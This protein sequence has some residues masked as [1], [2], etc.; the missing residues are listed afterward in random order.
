MCSHSKSYKNTQLTSIV[1]L[2]K[3]SLEV[4]LFAVKS[5]IHASF[6]MGNLKHRD[7]SGSVVSSQLMPPPCDASEPPNPDQTDVAIHSGG[8]DLGLCESDAETGGEVDENREENSIAS[9][10]PPSP[11]SSRTEDA[12]A[13]TTSSP[14]IAKEIAMKS[15]KAPSSGGLKL[16]N[17]KRPLSEML[18]PR[19]RRK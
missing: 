15:K 4:F 18:P 3:K 11:D 8:E 12:D 14:A 5:S 7:L 6:W 10:P 19:N 16:S 17:R 1:P 2:V 13:S 9:S